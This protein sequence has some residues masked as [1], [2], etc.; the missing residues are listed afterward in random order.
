MSPHEQKR[1]PDAIAD[2]NR[3]FAE[4]AARGEAG[5]MASLYTDDA[6]LLPPNAEPVSGRA[7]IERFWR[8]GIAMGIRGVELE[9]VRLEHADALA[10]E[11]GRYTLSLEPANGAAVTELAMY[12]LVYRLHQT[13]SWQRA[14]EIFNWTTADDLEG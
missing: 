2:S 3:R 5:P 4:A 1:V 9:T 7:A 11:I 10:Y 6:A 13:G 12:V 8:D 14:V